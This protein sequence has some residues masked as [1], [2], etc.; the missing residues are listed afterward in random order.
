MIVHRLLIERIPELD[1]LFGDLSL[2]TLAFGAIYIPL[3]V[4]IGRW[5]MKHQYKVESTMT[6][7]NSPGQLRAFRLLLDLETNSAD[8]ED[9]ESFK[10]LLKRLEKETTFSD[11][12]GKNEKDD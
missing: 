1:A 2:F 4:I 5:H 9:V 11:L 12:S 7:M 10:K 8:L 6:F 3:A